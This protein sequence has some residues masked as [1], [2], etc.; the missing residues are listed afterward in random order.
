[1]YHLPPL[2]KL[3]V[4]LNSGTLSVPQNLCVNEDVRKLKSNNR[5]NDRCLEL[6]KNKKKGGCYSSYL[7]HRLR[8]DFLVVLVA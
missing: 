1:M 6:Q 2:P 4:K 5:I 8:I 3:S 7:I